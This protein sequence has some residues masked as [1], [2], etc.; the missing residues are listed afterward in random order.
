[1]AV[2]GCCSVCLPMGGTRPPG[3]SGASGGSSGRTKLHSRV[4]NNRRPKLLWFDAGDQKGSSPLN[5]HNDLVHNDPRQ[6]LHHGLTPASLV[7]SADLESV[8]TAVQVADEAEH[9]G[10]RD[11]QSRRKRA[12]HSSLDESGRLVNGVAGEIPVRMPL[13]VRVVQQQKRMAQL[14]VVDA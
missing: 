8:R 4:L 3:V 6:L 10:E 7:D 1:M 14:A 11:L 2:D 9:C 5:A 12:L 13:S